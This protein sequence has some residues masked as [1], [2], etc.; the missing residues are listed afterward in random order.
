M[1]DRGRFEH[2]VR[3]THGG[4]HCAR[5]TQFYT[6]EHGE[7]HPIRGS[8]GYNPEVED[9]QRH[10]R[11][12]QAQEA[13]YRGVGREKH[14]Q[15]VIRPPWAGGLSERHLATIARAHG[16]NAGAHLWWEKAGLY[17]GMAERDYALRESGSRVDTRRVERSVGRAVK[18]SRAE[19]R[20][21]AVASATGGSD[22]PF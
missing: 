3:V 16:Q 14:A 13:R 1:S 15:T 2:A 6:D 18:Q 4:K 21:I 10:A 12:R 5:C 7:V 17:S 8:P 22:L 11:A 9:V 19:G 20:R